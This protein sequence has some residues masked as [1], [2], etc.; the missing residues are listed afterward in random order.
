MKSKITAFVIGGLVLFSIYY[1]LPKLDFF[2]KYRVKY[3]KSYSAFFN[4]NI[5][6]V[7]KKVDYC[8]HAVSIELID[9]KFY[10]CD[11]YTNSK[12][13]RF[14]NKANRGD[15]IIKIFGRSYFE[16]K[17]KNGEKYTFNFRDRTINN[18]FY[19]RY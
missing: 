15:S 8:D 2:K 12:G 17:K 14:M 7:I 16:L 18:D 9:G 6:G 4:E 1:F 19:K 13:Y 10:L 11:P 3:D 5:T